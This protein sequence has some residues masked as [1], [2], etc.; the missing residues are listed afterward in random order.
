MTSIPSLNGI[1]IGIF[2]RYK[3]LNAFDMSM[4]TKEVNKKLVVQAIIEKIEDESENAEIRT[5][6]VQGYEVPGKII[7]KGQQEKGYYPDLISHQGRKTELYEIELTPE[8]NLEKWRIFSLF[9]KKEHGTLHLVIPEVH[10]P[11]FRAQL[12]T[13]NI[14]AKLIYF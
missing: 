14:H 8:S 9:S 2:H 4:Q 12:T 13:H 3:T 6:L 11:F 1:P 5:S 10:L 7:P